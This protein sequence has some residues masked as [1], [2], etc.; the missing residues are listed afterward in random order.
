MVT[1]SNPGPTQNDFKSPVW[2]PKRTK[3]IKGAAKKCDLTKNNINV[4]SD[5]KAQSSFFN[6]IQPASLDIIKPWSQLLALA[7]WSCSKKWN[8]R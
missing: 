4:V 7:L 2:H 5:P 1:Q 8:L 6:T 3:V